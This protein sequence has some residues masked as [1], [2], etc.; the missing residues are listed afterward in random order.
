MIDRFMSSF[1][2]GSF[3]VLPDQ[4]LLRCGDEDVK[5]TPRNMDVLGY[6]AT[7]ADRV[8]TSNELLENFWSPV[9]SDHAVHKAISELRGALGDN[10]HRQRFIKTLPR[11]GYKLLI[12]PT[13]R[14]PATTTG[15]QLQTL[16]GT[17]TAGLHYRTLLG[18]LTVLV[19]LVGMLALATTLRPHPG[20][21]A[22]AAAGDAVTVGVEAFRSQGEDPQAIALMQEGLRTSLISQLSRLKEVRVVALDGDAGQHPP[23]EHVLRGTLLQADG[24]LRAMVHL[25]RSSDGVHEYSERFDLDRGGVFSVQDHI[26]SNI[27]TALRIHLDDRQR[28]LMYDWGTMNAN[29]FERFMQGDFYYNQF[30]PRDFERAIKLYQEAVQLDPQFVNAHVGMAAAANNLSVYSAPGKQR[31]LLKLVSRILQDVASLA[32]DHEALESI[33]AMEM[34]MAGTEYR[35]QEQILREQILSGHAPS[36]ALAHY[37]LFLIGARLYEEAEDFLDAAEDASPF[38][39]SPDESWDYRVA[40]AEPAQAIRLRKDQLMLRPKHIGMLAPL[41]RDLYTSGREQEAQWYLER[42]REEDTEGLTADYT[43]Q[44]LAALSGVLQP[45]SPELEALYARGEDF[46]FNNGTVAFVLGDIPRGVAFWTRLGPMQKRRLLNMVHISERYF[47]AEVIDAPAYQQLLER[48]DIG[49][50]WQRTLMEGVTAMRGVTGVSLGAEAS[51]AFANHRFVA[52]NTRWAMEP[53]QLPGA[54]DAY[55][56][57][58]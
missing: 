49:H 24:H 8:V 18:A 27:V 46:Y 56:A 14:E 57:E 32:P 16:A 45:G 53:A 42:L 52:R 29:A 39:L 44:V 40:I 37:A 31:E 41:V 21:A 38:E 36:Y 47:P 13:D 5:L 17:L 50:S 6:L 23:V 4:C 1:Y 35:R 22:V 15:R 20:S 7:H 11:R 12:P 26:V 25:V 51:A 9:A 3:E 10:V 48:L 43:A 58:M 55:L 28:A 2:L 30:N 33:R 19:S 34:R 54:R